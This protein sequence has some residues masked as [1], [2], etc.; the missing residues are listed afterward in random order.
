MAGAKCPD[1]VLERPLVLEVRP[2][3]A[4]PALAA[5]LLVGPPVALD[6]QQLPAL[7]AGEGLHPVLPLVMGLESP[8][9]LQRLGP[10]VV[11][12]V[13]ATL[14]AA[15]ARDTQHRPRLRPL[16][17]LRSS[18]ILRPVTPHVHLPCTKTITD[19]HYTHFFFLIARN[20]SI[21]T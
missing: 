13:P 7:P 8:E 14:F 16:E 4:E 19:D 12:I 1:V 3:G 6:G 11:Y 9:I 5:I 17:R 21:F 18:S 15:V 10:R 2:A 20:V